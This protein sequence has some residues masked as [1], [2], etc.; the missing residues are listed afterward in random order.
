MTAALAFD[1]EY[2]DACAE[3]ELGETGSVL[4]GCR[5]CWD[6]SMANSQAGTAAFGPSQDAALLRAVIVKI[7]PPGE[8]QDVVPRVRRWYDLMK[9]RRS[10]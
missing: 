9:A 8:R 4:F 7:F 1:R 5:G 6:R 2:C 3:A 10:A